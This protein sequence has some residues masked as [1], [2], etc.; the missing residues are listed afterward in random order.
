M[1]CVLKSPDPAA[2]PPPDAAADLAERTARNLRALAGGPVSR[3]PELLEAMTA[4]GTDHDLRRALARIA[5][6]AAS[7]T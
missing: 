7:L 2:E 3:L 4:V 1:R 5:E 6:T